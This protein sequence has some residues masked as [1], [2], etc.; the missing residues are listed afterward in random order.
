METKQCNVCKK[1]K[2]WR[3]YKHSKESKKLNPSQRVGTC[4]ECLSSAFW[5]WCDWGDELKRETEADM[6]KKNQPAQQ[7]IN[8][9]KRIENGQEEDDFSNHFYSH[10]GFYD[11]SH[12]LDY[13][14]KPAYMREQ[15]L[16]AE[17]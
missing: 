12:R 7:E 14:H 17:E 1:I 9:T 15:P 13:K 10:F 6:L 11:I 8:R 3:D 5:R 4:N 16:K 2:P